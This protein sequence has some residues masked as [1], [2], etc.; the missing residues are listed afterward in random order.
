M[1]LVFGNIGD[2]PT[3]YVC[4]RMMDRDVDFMLLDSRQYPQELNFTWGTEGGEVCGFVRQGT[5][6]VDLSEVSSVYLRN[7]DTLPNLG[8][9]V[10]TEEA[11]RNANNLGALQ[12]FTEFAPILIV[13][14]FSAM[15]TN[16]SKP[17]QAQIISNYFKVPRSLITNVP[18]EA[19]DFYEECRGRVI[20]K[21]VSGV[22]SIVKRLQTEDLQRLD[23]IRNCPT[24]FQECIPG[25]DVRVHTV[26]NRVFAVEIISDAVDY[27][28]ANREGEDRVMRDVTL[29]NDVAARCSALT[30]ATGLYL[31]GVDLRRS[32]D[33]DY[34]CFEVNPSPGFTFYE[35]C[36]G[37]GI[38]DA[39]IDLL[40]EGRPDLG[41]V[42]AA[43]SPE[44][45]AIAS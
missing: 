35:S 12:Y 41:V 15:A 37:Q 25:T 24:Q 38:G 16:S 26:G 17:Y 22:R 14:R 39:L 27:R 11:L 1:I 36:T 33:G 23:Q 28:Y 29:P 20:Y 10:S 8:E 5:R 6:T 19:R 32:P 2:E 40:C 21:S 45:A 3:A 31:G 30:A 43:V 18:T 34:Y 44:R 13:N 42:S 7:M 9:V 4:S